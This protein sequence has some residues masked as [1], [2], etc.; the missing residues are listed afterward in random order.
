MEYCFG[1]HEHRVEAPN[2]DP[3]FSTTSRAASHSLPLWKFFHP[4]LTLVM[5]LPKSILFRMGDGVAGALTMK[6]AFFQ[7]ID[8]IRSGTNLSHS[9]SSYVTIFHGNSIFEASRARKNN[10]SAYG[11]SRADRRR[12]H[13]GHWMDFVDCG[14]PSPR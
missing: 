10:S 9:E 12:G 7:Q 5:S 4:V 1:R 8:G 3:S 11:R 14:L 13:R 2:F 6:R